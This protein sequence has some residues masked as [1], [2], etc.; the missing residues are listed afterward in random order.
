MLDQEQEQD[1]GVW[2]NDGVWERAWWLAAK[3]NAKANFQ[4]V[5]NANASIGLWNEIFERAGFSLPDEGKGEET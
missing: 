3:T 2:E 5:N 1:E 4:R